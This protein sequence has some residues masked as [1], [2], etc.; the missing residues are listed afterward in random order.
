VIKKVL[1][2]SKNI[3]NTKIVKKGV[4]F[5][6]VGQNKIDRLSQKYFSLQGN[7]RCARV[8]G[9]LGARR[10]ESGQGTVIDERRLLLATFG[11]LFE[12]A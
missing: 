4:F 1:K 2:I 7:N 11:C 9:V 12:P 8:P 5:G 6:C 10:A 3:K